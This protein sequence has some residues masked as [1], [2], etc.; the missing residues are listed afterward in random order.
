M[1]VKFNCKYCKKA[2]VTKQRKKTHEEICK[3]KEFN[4]LKDKE[5]EELKVR[6]ENTI[7]YLNN[8]NNLLKNTIEDLKSII[9]NYKDKLIN[10]LPSQ[11]INNQTINNSQTINSN[12]I[13]VNNTIIQ[14]LDISLERFES[15]I[16][17]IGE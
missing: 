10:L 11:T 8:E 7:A 6:Y 14:P 5:I 17:E 1:D 3:I 15:I 12:L 9:D 2:F 16:K 4:E 13:T